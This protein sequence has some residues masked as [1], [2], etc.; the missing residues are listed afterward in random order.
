[1]D[2]TASTANII[3]V[4]KALV[5]FIVVLYLAFLFVYVIEKIS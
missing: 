4:L 3:L 2:L 1:M 5:P